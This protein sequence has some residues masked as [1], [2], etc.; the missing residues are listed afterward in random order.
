[1]TSTT[2]PAHD[3]HMSASPLNDSIKLGRVAGFPL[4]MNWSVLV[5]AWLLTWSLA[6]TSLPHHAMGH[7]EVTY[8]LTGL[9]TAVVFFG[10][11]L[12][13]E[14]AHALVAR[15]H[16]V[17]VKGITLW[18]FGGIAT[19]GGEPPSPRADFQIAVVGPAA[20]LG[21]AAVFQ[22]IAVGLQRLGVGHLIV[23]A[24]AWL[25]GINVMLGV[26]NLLPGAPLDGGRVLRAF[27]WH[28]HGDRFRAAVTAAK[29][30]AVVAFLLIGFGGLEFFA[31]VSMSGLW[32]V[33]VGWFVLSASRAEGADALMRGALVGMT[34]AEVMSARPVIALGSMSVDKFIDGD[35]LGRRH[36]AYPV[37]GPD[38]Q[39]IGMLTQAQVRRV[40]RSNRSSTTVADVALPLTAVPI[41]SPDDALAGVAERLSIDEGGRALVFDQDRLAGILTMGDV[42]RSAELRRAGRTG[43]HLVG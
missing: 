13:H 16:G 33:F 15:R 41:A 38:G 31:G 21:L 2:T 37:V 17:Q 7:A 29:A 9:A 22:L 1:M 25:A 36:S 30:G 32:L 5:I 35:A 8:W 11:L 3:E 23:V 20:S 42:F 40:R 39:I 28:R 10:S 4:A 19:L 27:L 34:V 18:L 14:L 6:T 24:A 12:A 26:F 43:H